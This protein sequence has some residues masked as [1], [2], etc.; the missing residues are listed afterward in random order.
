MHCSHDSCQSVFIS[1]PSYSYHTLKIDKDPTQVNCF[2]A[3]TAR[4]DDIRIK[5]LNR[6]QYF[7]RADCEEH[8]GCLYK[9]H[10]GHRQKFKNQIIHSINCGKNACGHCFQLAETMMKHQTSCARSEYENCYL[11][12]KKCGC[13]EDI[14]QHLKISPSSLAI[15]KNYWLDQQVVKIENESV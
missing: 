5:I 15:K 13:S 4:S 1:K 11:F 2:A 7:L 3:N 9:K 8:H 12:H 6:L 10:H 14:Y